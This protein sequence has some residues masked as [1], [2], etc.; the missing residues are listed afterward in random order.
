MKK[1][2]QSRVVQKTI[3]NKNNNIHPEEI[4]DESTMISFSK[5]QQNEHDIKV[6]EDISLKERILNKLQLIQNTDLNIIT[7]HYC[8]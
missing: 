6:I 7:T 2:N 5:E 1:K 3:D 8:D 4:S